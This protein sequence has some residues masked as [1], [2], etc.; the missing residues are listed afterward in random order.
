MGPMNGKVPIGQR[1]CECVEPGSAE[2]GFSMPESCRLHLGLSSAGGECPG[3]PLSR[4]RKQTS[5]CAIHVSSSEEASKRGQGTSW[6]MTDGPRV[7]A[8]A[9]RSFLLSPLTRAW[10]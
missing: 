7:A 9:Q 6:K 5:V 3:S 8:P 4:W 2:A 10:V 1:A